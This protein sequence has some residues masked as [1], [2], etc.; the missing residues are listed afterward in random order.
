MKTLKR[1]GEMAL[2]PSSIAKENESA[3]RLFAVSRVRVIVYSN[4]NFA[5]MII[6]FLSPEKY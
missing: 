4:E 5:S 2:H 6:L 3:R 1:R